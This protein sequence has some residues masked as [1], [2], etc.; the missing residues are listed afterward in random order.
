MEIINVV[1]EKNKSGGRLPNPP[2]TL[3][4]MHKKCLFAMLVFSVRG[5][6]QLPLNSVVHVFAVLQIPDI[7]FDLDLVTTFCLG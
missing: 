7:F 1:G 5:P 4:C 2:H 3:L 6:T